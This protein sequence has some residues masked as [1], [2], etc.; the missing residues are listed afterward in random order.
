MLFSVFLACLCALG[1]LVLMGHVGMAANL[2][3]I[4][5]TPDSQPQKVLETEPDGVEEFIEGEDGT[6]IRA[7]HKGS[8]STVVLIHGAGLSVVTMNLMW[9]L[10]AGA[11]FRVIAYDH[12]GHGK[13]T[14][15]SDG[16][17]VKPMVDDLKAVLSYFNVWNGILVGHSTGAFLAIRYLLRFPDES[18]RRVRG[19]VSIAG[20]AGNILEG[21]PHNRFARGLI[22]TGVLQSLLRTKFFGWGLAASAFGHA[23][24]PSRIRVFLKL[25]LARPMQRL[26]PLFQDQIRLN[27]YARLNEIQVPW[28]V[29]ASQNDKRMAPIHAEKLQAGIPGAEIEWIEEAGNM[30]VWECPGRI[31]EMVKRLDRQ[32]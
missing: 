32:G 24:S 9:R 15:G 29:A 31:V 23:A 4:H 5:D 21:A 22:Q 28:I 1:I 6:L 30:M 12:R 27:D 17:G 10:L 11:G 18:A 13:S 19:A 20:F 25:M 26:I 7:L 8:G 14:I 2:F 3:A 16:M